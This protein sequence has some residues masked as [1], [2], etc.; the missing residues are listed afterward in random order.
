MYHEVNFAFWLDNQEMRLGTIGIRNDINKKKSLKSYY[1]KSL[2]FGRLAEVY[3][4]GVKKS[5]FLTAQE[6]L[7]CPCIN[8]YFARSG[9]TLASTRVH[10]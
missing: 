6:G 9:P 3:L 10:L 7:S 1:P 4:R 5:G 2:Y 8:P